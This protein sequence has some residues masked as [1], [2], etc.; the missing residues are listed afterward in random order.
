MNKI[1][2]KNYTDILDLK[3]NVENH[4][5]TFSVEYA[6][7]KIY[8]EL[9]KSKKFSIQNVID[10]MTIKIMEL[11]AKKEWLKDIDDDYID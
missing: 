8:P 1:D 10:Y 5:D 6:I 2:L 9:M 3:Q 11:D 7:N 4:I